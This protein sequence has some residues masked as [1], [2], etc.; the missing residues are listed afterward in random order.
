MSGRDR[1]PGQGRGDKEAGGPGDGSRSLVSPG[2]RTLSMGLPAST[3]T[4]PAPVQRKH[5]PA[6]ETLMNSS[7]EQQARETASW[8]NV[9][10]RPD[11]HGEPAANAHVRG[12]VVQLMLG[13]NEATSSSQSSEKKG[14]ASSSQ[15]PTEK[16][17]APQ[18]STSPA[19]DINE[20]GALSW[21]ELLARFKSMSNDQKA[22]LYYQIHVREQLQRD[23]PGSLAKLK[24]SIEK[25]PQGQTLAQEFGYLE[26]FKAQHG[27]TASSSIEGHD[28]F[29]SPILTLYPLERDQSALTG[30][31][32]NYTHRPILDI[33]IKGF[34]LY[35]RCYLGLYKK[36]SSEG[37][38]DITADAEG[39][40]QLQN[41]DLMNLG[42]PFKALLWCED[43]L[44]NKEHDGSTSGEK[45]KVPPSP[46]VRSFLVPLT[47]AHTLLDT[48]Q[49][50]ARP[51]DQDRGAG[52]FGNYGTPDVYAETLH[53]LAG[54]LVSFFAEYEDFAPEA[55]K[56]NQT[57]LPLSHLQQHLTG[58]AGDPRDMTTSGIMAQHG[59]KGHEATFAAPYD[60][61]LT[62]YSE[63]ISTENILFKDAT[64][65]SIPATTGKF[66][67]Q[68]FDLSRFPAVKAAATSRGTTPPQEPS[69]E[70]I[71][72]QQRWQTF[73][74]AYGQVPRTEQSS[75]STAHHEQQPEAADPR[76]Q[77]A[78]AQVL[79]ESPLRPEMFE[80]VGN[81][82]GGDCLFH[83]L[84][85]K[86]LSPREILDLRQRIAARIEETPD[87]ELGKN[88]NSNQVVATLTQT[89]VIGEHEAMEMVRGRD[90][91]PNAVY[92]S[93][94]AVPGIYTGPDEL[95]QW[96]ALEEQVVIVV[97]APHGQ[98]LAYSGEGSEILLD[99]NHAPEGL[100]QLRDIIDGYPIALYKSGNHYERIKGIKQ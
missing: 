43:Y 8:M 49:H 87:T 47:D 41:V 13:G 21:K 7:A 77:Y 26:V 17:S 85:G 91:V 93:M 25:Q 11:I 56:P 22:N 10:M 52:Q 75:S 33:E 54:S 42:N 37:H 6:A 82:G 39:K 88:A 79:E 83:A 9:A 99:L 27:Y 65:A 92:A 48:G 81:A 62:A 90:Q 50:V 60:P 64:Q 14:E 24:T 34:R 18:E 58:H 5:D 98:V 84:A 44:S 95:M 74:E 70:V 51:L 61:A 80:R 4:P 100:E 2:K 73:L 31:R 46:V 36:G 45:N 29:G 20:L 97:D 96:C 23:V 38:K 28:L 55:E 71:E 69:P 63:Y 16:Q 32:R 72:L 15:D 19:V 86:D 12:N 78:D 57:V 35:A 67:K 3:G 59:R 1:K 94:V 76:F 68:R 66:A 89:P 30:S 53:P 40:V